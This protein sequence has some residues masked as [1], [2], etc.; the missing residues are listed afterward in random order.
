MPVSS[1]QTEQPE[2]ALATASLR[3]TKIL[4]GTSGGSRSAVTGAYITQIECFSATGPYPM[5]GLRFSFNNG[6]AISIG[7]TSGSAA[8]TINLEND[9]VTTLSLQVV[10]STAYG[11]GSGI[12]GIYVETLRRPPQHYSNDSSTPLTSPNAWSIVTDSATGTPIRHAVLVG[13]FGTSGS[14]VDSAGFYFKDD[15][16]I[17]QGMTDVVYNSWQM[18]PAAPMNV[19]SATVSNQTPT[20]QTMS[21]SFSESVASTYTFST[22]AGVTAGVKTTIEAGIPFVAKGEVEVSATVS[23]NITLGVATTINDT[24]NYSANLTVPA[25]GSVTATATAD[26]YALTGGY[27]ATFAEV[28]AHAGPVTRQVTGTISGVTAYNVTVTYATT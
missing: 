19:A 16:L 4:G 22:T 5:G 10:S 6:Q 14:A 12:G 25:S 13:Y 2:D 17:S 7:T 1:T 21:I 23:L 27:S 9:T 11:S 3:A 20:T 18:N 26:S 15:V 24:F 8:T 28:W